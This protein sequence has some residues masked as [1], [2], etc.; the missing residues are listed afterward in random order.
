[1]HPSS[2]GPFTTTAG[3]QGNRFLTALLTVST[4]SSDCCVMT[5]EHVRRLIEKGAHL[6]NAGMNGDLSKNA[7][8]FDLVHLDKLDAPT[9]RI[10]EDCQ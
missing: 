7:L 1:M 5:S 9:A 2:D 8:A 3:S 10:W 6:F 4:N